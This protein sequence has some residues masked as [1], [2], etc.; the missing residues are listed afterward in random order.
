MVKA[1]DPGTHGNGAVVASGLSVC[2]LVPVLGVHRLDLSLLGRLFLCQ[3]N[4]LRR[5]VQPRLN[6]NPS[7]TDVPGLG[8]GLPARIFCY[9]FENIVFFL[10]RSVVAAIFLG[11]IS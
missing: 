1:A 9:I 3:N 2:C 10:V 5:V 7:A 6:R 8:L 4:P 11:A